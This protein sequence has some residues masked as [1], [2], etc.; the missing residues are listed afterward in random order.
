MSGS[1]CKY[2]AEVVQIGAVVFIIIYIYLFL[3]II[4]NIYLYLSLFPLQNHISYKSGAYFFCC[5]PVKQ[6]ARVG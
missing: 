6:F 5:H 4:I 3:L 1:W 2:G